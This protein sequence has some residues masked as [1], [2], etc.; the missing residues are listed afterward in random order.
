MR[1]M[2]DKILKQY[3]TAMTVSSES[4]SVDVK[5]FFQPVRAKSWQNTVEFH[6][7]LGE[8][9]RG[10]YVYIG[11]ADT[12][13][14]EGDTLTVGNRDYLFRRAE[15]FYYGD[16]AVYLWGLCMEKGGDDKWGTQS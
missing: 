12:A 10:Q 14:A 1:K 9:P 5:G 11:P 6:T 16:Q 3:G 2:V 13:V 4:G 8:I 15:P 7:P